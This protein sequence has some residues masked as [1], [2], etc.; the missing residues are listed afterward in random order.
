[1]Q[2]RSMREKMIENMCINFIKRVIDDD[3][4]FEKVFIRGKS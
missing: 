2:T 3:E 4:L 1:M